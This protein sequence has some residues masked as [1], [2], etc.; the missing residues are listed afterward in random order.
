MPIEPLLLIAAIA[1]VG[2][3]LALPAG[4]R[5]LATVLDVIDGSVGMYT[6]REILG[7]DTTTARQRRIDRRQAREQAELERRIGVVPSAEDGVSGET[8]P[9][10]VPVRTTLAPTRIV[11]SGEG[12]RV[13]APDRREEVASEGTGGDRPEPDD[14]AVIHRDRRLWDAAFATLGLA[15]VI[16]AAVAVLPGPRGGVL[17][18]TGTPAPAETSVGGGTRGSPQ[19]VGAGAGGVPSAVPSAGPESSATS[20]PDATASPSGPPSVFG[21]SPGRRLLGGTAAASSAG[22][23]AT[24]ELEVE[25]DAL[26]GFD[27]AVRV[28][29]GAFEPVDRV[30][31]GAR[32]ADVALP[33]GKTAT[34][35][36]S[37]LGTDDE[38]IDGAVAEIGPIRASRY[39]ES[40]DRVS[41]GGTWRRAAGPSLLGGG[42]TFTR[43]TGRLEFDFSGTDVAWVATKTPMSGRA[44]VRID[45]EVIDTVDLR[46]D[47]VDYRRVVFRWHGDAGDHTLEIRALGDGRVDA[48][49][50]LVLR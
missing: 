36:V 49:A 26:S 5:L 16:T 42:V 23:R 28:D 9:S 1:A 15:I 21:S 6:V 35:R 17:D 3:L 29:D 47:S 44:E 14:G 18:T 32:S 24:W 31:A 33:L 30:G 22:V 45:G 41:L 27:I 37:A 10:F 20:S 19:P 13:G 11:V 38:V 46:S 12:S 8:G 43:G 34:I 40:S 50:F 48:D 39:Q 2:L 4:R 7:R 25:S